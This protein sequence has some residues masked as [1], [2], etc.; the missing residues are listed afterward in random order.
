MPRCTTQTVNSSVVPCRYIYKS[1]SQEKTTKRWSD[2]IHFTWPDCCHSFRKMPNK[3]NKKATQSKHVPLRY[4]MPLSPFSSRKLKKTEIDKRKLKYLTGEWF[5]ETKSSRYRDK[6]HGTDIIRSSLTQRKPV[7]I[8]EWWLEIRFHCSQ[9]L[10]LKQHKK[11]SFR[12]LFTTVIISAIVYNHSI[13]FRH[14]FTHVQ[15][16]APKLRGRLIMSLFGF[17]FQ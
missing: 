17:S 6:I 10:H 3:Q 1:S 12:Q 8:R 4:N 13:Q 7:T 9:P 15:G 14:V 11:C 16:K 2:Y 5:Y